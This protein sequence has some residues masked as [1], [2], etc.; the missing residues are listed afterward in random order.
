[1]II[2][3]QSSIVINQRNHLHHGIF[4]SNLLSSLWAM[5]VRTD[6]AALPG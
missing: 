4:T 5:A 3:H 1:M 6:N 2:N